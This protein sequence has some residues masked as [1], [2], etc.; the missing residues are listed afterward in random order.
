MEFR[1]I[2]ANRKCCYLRFASMPPLPASAPSLAAPGAGLPGPELV[3]ARLLFRYR[4]WRSNPAAAA[5]TLTRELERMR[6]IIGPHRGADGAQRVLIPRLRGMEDSSRHW[7]LFMTVAHVAIVNRGILATLP[8]L[9]AGR[10]PGR[11]ASTAAVKPP[12]DAG[13]EAMAQLERSCAAL[14]EFR[15]APLRTAARHAHPWF[16][17]LDGQDWFF[18]AGFHMALHRRQL[19]LIA[20]GLRG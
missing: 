10:V 16:G 18:L 3:V 12:V 7:S 8:E 15:D 11:T 14:L 4:A 2:L 6:A 17:R 1:L 19:E 5:R 20:A 13:A 9:L